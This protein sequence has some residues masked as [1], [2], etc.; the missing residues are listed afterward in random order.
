LTKILVT[1]GE[2]GPKLGF[3]LI[4]NHFPLM[5]KFITILKVLLEHRSVLLIVSELGLKII[6]WPSDGLFLAGIEGSYLA[7]FHLLRNL[8]RIFG[9]FGQVASILILRLRGPELES[10]RL[11]IWGR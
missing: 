6:Y 7:H 9:D 11:R 1:V 3:I 2:R 8:I 10:F 5:I 4:L